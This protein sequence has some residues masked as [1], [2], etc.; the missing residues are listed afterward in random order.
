MGVL[1]RKRL[2]LSKRLSLNLSTLWLGLSIEP[3]GTKVSVSRKRARLHLGIPERGLAIGGTCRSPSRDKAL[4]PTWRRAGIW[5]SVG[6]GLMMG[7]GVDDVTNTEVLRFLNRGEGLGLFK[8]CFATPPSG[9]R[10]WHIILCVPDPASLSRQEREI[11]RPGVGLQ[12]IAVL[13]ELET[14]YPR[15]SFTVAIHWQR[16][17]ATNEYGYAFRDSKTGQALYHEKEPYQ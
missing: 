1:F 15:F 5:L 6:L 11:M 13:K 3:P 12:A 2:R 7:C 10:T 9:G 4:S 17:N 14:R 16:E 8:A